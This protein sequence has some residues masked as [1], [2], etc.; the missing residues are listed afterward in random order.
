MRRT[1]TASGA[2][3]RH[4]DISQPRLHATPAY[5]WGGGGQVEGNSLAYLGSVVRLSSASAPPHGIIL[6]HNPLGYP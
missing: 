4:I 6:Q 1:H 3:Y 2:L 5:G